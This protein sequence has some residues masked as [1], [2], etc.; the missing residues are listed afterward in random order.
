MLL[1]KPLHHNFEKHK[2]W[3]CK[4]VYYYNPNKPSNSS[5]WDDSNCY[6]CPRCG[7]SY[8]PMFQDI[9]VLGNLIRNLF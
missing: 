3:R 9:N 5:D 6:D 7:K 1:K 4:M 8:F 2:C